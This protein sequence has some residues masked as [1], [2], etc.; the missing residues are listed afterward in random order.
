MGAASSGGRNTS[1]VSSVMGQ[2]AQP[3][4]APQIGPDFFFLGG[5]SQQFLILFQIS[6]M[7]LRQPVSPR[8]VNKYVTVLVGLQVPASIAR[9]PCSQTLLPPP[10]SRDNWLNRAAGEGRRSRS[11]SG[12]SG[13]A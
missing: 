5:G 12:R 6:N 11:A 10:G 2:A 4:L 7:S 3:F 9:Q 13:L 1:N 8:P